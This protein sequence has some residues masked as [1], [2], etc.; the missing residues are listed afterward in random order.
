MSV[1]TLQCILISESLQL[2]EE[3]STSGS[4]SDVRRGVSTS[5]CFTVSIWTLPKITWDATFRSWRH[6]ISRETHASGEIHKLMVVV[7]SSVKQTVSAD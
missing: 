2:K 4:V 7:L 1:L 6:V 5:D 3:V